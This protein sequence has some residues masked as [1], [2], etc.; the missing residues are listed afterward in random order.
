MPSDQHRVNTSP[1]PTL[2]RPE[3]S[4]AARSSSGL[5]VGTS[6]SL[7]AAERA[8]DAAIAKEADARSGLAASELQH[9]A[10]RKQLGTAQA[11][12]TELEQ[13]RATKQQEFDTALAK[14]QQALTE[15][16]AEIERLRLDPPGL[17]AANAEIKRFEAQ[18]RELTELGTT[19][20]AKIDEQTAAIANAAT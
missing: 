16:L 18:V 3:F 2:S 20:Q 4:T 11:R 14:V 15:A 19:L 9:T 7:G 8:R 5:D 17:A 13:L 10:P 12:V 1:N 6:I